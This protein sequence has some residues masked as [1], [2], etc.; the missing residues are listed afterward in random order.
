MVAV[1]AP[2]HDLHDE[3]EIF[4]KELQGVCELRDPS[5]RI[6]LLGDFNGWVGVRR[7]ETFEVLGQYGDCTR[8]NDN[9]QKLIELCIEISLFI[10]NIWFKHKEAHSFTWK[11]GPTEV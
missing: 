11:R 7:G 6:I 2:T 8:V 9:G 5:E 4:W 3:N 1:Y 10:S